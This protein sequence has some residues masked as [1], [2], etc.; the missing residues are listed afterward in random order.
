[1][2]RLFVIGD[3]H[4]CA[5]ELEKMLK[6]VDGKI[7]KDDT[8][9]CLGDYIDR[10]PDSKRV[11]DILLGRANHPNKHVFL[12]GNHEVMMID[13]EDFWPL[14][15][16]IETLRSYGK[17][18]MDFPFFWQELIPSHKKFFLDTQMYYQAGRV[19]CV[20]AGLDPDVPLEKQNDHFMLWDR[21]CYGYMGAYHD[22]EFVVIGHTPGRAVIECT[23]QLAID[24]SCVFGGSLSCA[25]LD[26]KGGLIDCLE[27]RSGYSW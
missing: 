24:T 8:I 23:N 13:G 3:I 10:G 25:I 15:G 17:T 7:Q 21:T 27:V 9:I 26:L 6:I 20:H 12:R 16:G 5:D 19:V 22:D 14:N 2:E 18:P 1:M 11:V 4:G